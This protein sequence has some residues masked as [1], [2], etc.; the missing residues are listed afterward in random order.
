M[1]NAQMRFARPD[2]KHH[3]DFTPVVPLADDCL[4]SVPTSGVTT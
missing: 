1:A 4:L 3:R 2:Y